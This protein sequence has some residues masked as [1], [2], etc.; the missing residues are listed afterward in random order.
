MRALW[1]ILIILVIALIA[2]IVY[3]IVL[4]NGLQQTGSE[5]MEEISR[6][7]VIVAETETEPE[8]EA[9]SESEAEPAAEA[10]SETESETGYAAE[11]EFTED[12]SPE[13]ETAG[14]EGTTGQG[15]PFQAGIAGL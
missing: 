10:E 4:G 13:E 9:E 14:S 1:T 2:A 5:R 15:T 3:E 6:E 11:A 7:P 12:F 8:T